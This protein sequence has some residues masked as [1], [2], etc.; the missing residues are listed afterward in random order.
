MTDAILNEL[1]KLNP[2]FNLLIEAAYV[3]GTP[4]QR[5]NLSVSFPKIL[6]TKKM[7]E[8]QNG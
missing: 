7:K 4:G 6:T 8:L 2:P 5:H 3:Q 1:L